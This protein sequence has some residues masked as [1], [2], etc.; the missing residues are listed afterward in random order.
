MTET[1]NPTIERLRDRLVSA[2][3]SGSIAARA[4]AR[5]WQTFAAYFPEVGD[6]SVLDLGG[7]TSTWINAPAR[8]REW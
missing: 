7:T 3:S 8:P 4:R 6:M 1:R 2:R 5:R